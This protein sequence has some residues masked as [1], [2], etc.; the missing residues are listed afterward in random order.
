MTVHTNTQF[1]VASRRVRASCN[2]RLGVVA[3]GHGG[4]HA[5]RDAA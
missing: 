1:R 2:D 5:E 3:V 4:E